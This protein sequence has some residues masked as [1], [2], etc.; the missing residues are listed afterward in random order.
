MCFL[1]LRIKL[2]RM[3]GSFC[4][5]FGGDFP[6]LSRSHLPS[7]RDVWAGATSAEYLI[8]NISFVCYIFLSLTACTLSIGVLPAACIRDACCTYPSEDGYAP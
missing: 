7:P 1:L 3:L 4:T 5:C 2:A 8:A 6:L